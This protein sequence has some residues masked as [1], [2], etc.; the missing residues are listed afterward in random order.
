MTPL[1]AVTGSRELFMNL[2]LREL[3]GKYKRSILGWSWS[4]LNP[5]A[6]VVIFSVVFRF[7]FK[8]TFPEGDPSGLKSFALA[9]VIG[10]L[11]WNFLSNGITGSMAALIGNSNLIKKVYFPRQ[12]LVVSNVASWVVSLLIELTVLSVILVIAGNFVVPWLV[13]VLLLMLIQSLFVT[14]LGL[15]LSV[16]NVYFRDVEHLVGVLLQFWF[17]ATPVVYPIDVV[18]TEAT[19]LGWDLPVRTLYGLNPMVRFVEAYRDCLYHLRFPPLVDIAYLVG[20]AAV[21]LVVGGLL[22]RRLEPK[23]AEEL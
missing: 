21:A 7:F 9:L 13:P 10:L 4:L 15:G 22:F 23:L 20:T 2:T 14:G 8:L 16:L 5:L 17:Y 3:R 11:P 6:T 18:P 12:V 1:S 19:V